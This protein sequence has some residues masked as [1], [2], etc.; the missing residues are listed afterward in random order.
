MFNIYT[1][2][3]GAGALAIAIEGPAKAE[4]DFQDNK[5]GTCG[6]SFTCPEPGDYQV[7]IKFNDEHIP[8]SPFNVNISPPIGDAKKLTVHSL[9]TKGLEINKP[10]IFSINVNGARGK[11]DAKVINPSGVQ[12]SCVVQEINDDSYAIRFVPREN[13][14][15][16]V[17]VSFNGV[18]IPES[19]FRVFVGLQSADPGRVFASG[20]GL[21]FGETGRPCEFLIDTLHAGAGA[22]AI[23]VDGPAKVQLDCK[24]VGEGYKVSFVPSA[25]GDYLTTIKFVGTNIAGSPFKCRVTGNHNL[26]KIFYKFN[27]Y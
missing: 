7:S 6:V 14:A 5:D 10:C 13:G 23:T 15:H 26:I 16:W 11:I 12:D 24:E 9:R 22:L 19:P 1:R 25:P 3:A 18:D 2:E 20:D 17:H 4:I 21:H 27:S 8:E